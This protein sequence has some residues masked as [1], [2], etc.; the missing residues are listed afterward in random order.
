MRVVECNGA[1]DAD[2]LA[3]GERTDPVPEPDEVVIDVRAAGIN[4]A[5]LA[6]R[7]GNYPPP[8]GAS[9]ILGLECSGVVS[10]VGADVERW[11]AGDEVC[12]LLSGGGYAER[13]AVPS[14]QVLPVPAGVDVEAAAALPEA[15]ATVWSNV[16]M[17]AGLHE[18]E[19]LLVHGGA[20]GIGT[21]AI[22]LGKA[23][24]TRVAVTAGSAEKLARCAELGADIGIDYKQQDFVDALREATDDHGADVILDVVGGPYLPRNIE[25]LATSGRLVVIGLQGGTTGELPLHR[26][27]AKRGAVLATLLR[28][29][30]PGEK[31]AIIASVEEHVWPLVEAGT[32]RPVVQQ[33]FDL[34]DVREAHRLMESGGHVGKVLLS[35]S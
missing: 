28:S 20:G 15:A 16:F 2:V 30:P 17:L 22:Q 27:W 7:R 1:G 19:T 10:A 35:T 23:F 3:L 8:P 6:Q 11:R 26:L 33:V 9:D 12:A 4:P 21:M 13:V 5:D 29:R 34:D 18:G 24:G 14:A 25:A 31:A 32:V